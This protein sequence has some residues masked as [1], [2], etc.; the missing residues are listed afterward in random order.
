MKKVQFM[1]LMAAVMFAGG[2]SAVAIGG[3]FRTEADLPD[4]SGGIPL[5]HEDL[6]A[7]IDGGIELTEAD[8]VENPFSWLGGLVY[9]D[10]DPTTNILLLDSQDELDF[11]T[12]DVW[13]SN[14]LFDSGEV[15]TGISL[16]SDNLTVPYDPFVDPIVVPT[17]S[18]TDN[19]IHISYDA[20]AG[21]F[22]FTGGTAEFQVT[23]GSSSAPVPEPAT[24]SLLGMGL[25]GLAARARRKK[26]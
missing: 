11:Q 21:F 3:D 20:G 1:A 10:Y 25:I 24:M 7:T 23:L 15:I 2:A 5:V 22:D 13:I 4:I 14:I 8:F 9:V 26:A 17:F 6:G 19:S 18:H 16:I 12:F